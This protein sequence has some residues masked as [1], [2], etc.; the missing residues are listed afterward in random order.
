MGNVQ[1]TMCAYDDVFIYTAC[2]TLPQH[3]EKHDQSTI[4]LVAVEGYDFDQKFPQE[5]LH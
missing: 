2:G 1:S 5:S 4:Q 3:V